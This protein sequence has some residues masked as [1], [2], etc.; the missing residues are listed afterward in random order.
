MGHRA[1]FVIIREGAASAYCDPWG[2]LGCV[3]LL[4]GG[5][6]QA[7][8][9]AEQ[10][11]ATEELDEW[12]FAEGGFL[13]DHDRSTLIAFGYP[14]GLEEELEELDEVLMQEMEALEAALESGPRAF[15]KHI[16]S[17]WSGWRLRW[18]DRG[19]D[20]FGE[21]LRMLDI[22]TIKTQAESHP[23]DTLS[24]EYQA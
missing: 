16:A 10:M 8:A 15:L 22:S 4:A 5:P 23:Q 2:A 24:V 11:E 13:I 7:T 3:Y 19:V 18:D 17:R 12:G 1:N 14:A 6:V 20:A 9:F 21:Y